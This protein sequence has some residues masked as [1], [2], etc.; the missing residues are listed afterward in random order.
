MLT[1]SKT[2][3]F[4]LFSGLE[5]LC[6]ECSNDY[7]SSI[8]SILFKILGKQFKIPGIKQDCQNDL[9]GSMRTYATLRN[10]LFHNDN[11]TTVITYGK[12]KEKFFNFINRKLFQQ[13]RIYKTFAQANM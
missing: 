4:L 5:S 3:H 9:I 8:E 7:K 12:Q 2:K 13:L 11:L 10:C 1:N 6:R